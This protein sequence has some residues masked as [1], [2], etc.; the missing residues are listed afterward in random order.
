MDDATVVDVLDGLEDGADEISGF[1]RHR[2][3]SGESRV[4]VLAV[5]TPHSSCP[6]RICGQRARL[7]CR[8]RNRDRDCGRSGG[9]RCEQGWLG[10]AEGVVDTSK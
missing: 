5:L 6:W 1:T 2:V 9:W 7:L 8:D 10:L 3:R 4:D